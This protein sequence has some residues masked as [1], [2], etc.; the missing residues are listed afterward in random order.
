M[1][2]RLPFGHVAE[3]DDDVAH[4]PLLEALELAWHLEDEGSPIARPVLAALTLAIER[5]GG[6]RAA[7]YS[8]ELFEPAVK[9]LW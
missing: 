6:C 2:G 9:T 4:V 5:A 3:L 8:P 1:S 7:L